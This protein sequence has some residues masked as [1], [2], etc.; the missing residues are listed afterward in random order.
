M[1]AKRAL[2]LIGSPRGKKSASQKLGLYLLA[3]LQARGC[4]T[5]HL[6]VYSVVRS[7]KKQADLIAAVTR[8]DVLIVS[9]PLYVDTLPAAV[10]ETLEI[11]AQ[12][13]DAVTSRRRQFLAIS[14]CGFPEA[15]HNEPA[16]AEYRLFAQQLGFD[17][18]G[19]LMLGGGAAIGDRSLEQLGRMGQTVRRS[20]DLTAEA[21]AQ[22][23]PA[24]PEAI[25]LMAQPMMPRW[26]YLLF[27]EIG[28]RVSA[29]KY[30]VLGKL[31]ARPYA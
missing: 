12:H 16:I 26:I 27:A 10:I 21:L 24:P 28:W 23:Q 20:L 29:R 5:E 22:S 7:A 8:A 11:I 3:Q 30:G 1:S 4:E 9:A 13:R 15:Q 19:G 31:R 17:W 25:Q 2:L 18:A 14:N 6:R